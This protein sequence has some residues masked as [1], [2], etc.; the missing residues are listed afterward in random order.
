MQTHIIR[1]CHRCSPVDDVDNT[2]DNCKEIFGCPSVSPANE[3][4]RLC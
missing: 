2:G 3:N 1:T 4:K